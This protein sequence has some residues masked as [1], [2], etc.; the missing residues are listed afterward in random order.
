MLSE[1]KNHKP[2]VTADA[3]MRGE[4][5]VTPPKQSSR[6]RFQDTNEDD[7]MVSFRSFR[8]AEH[9][10]QERGQQ[11]QSTQRELKL[12]VQEGDDRQAQRLLEMRRKQQARQ[13][14][15]EMAPPPK[16]QQVVITNCPPRPIVPPVQPTPKPKRRRQ[17]PSPTWLDS[18]CASVIDATDCCQDREWCADNDDDNIAAEQNKSRPRSMF[19]STI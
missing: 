1:G 12:H 6:S 10:R 4:H 11:L 7:H 17:R 8:R 19:P 18:L 16:Q 15:R 2:K 14:E 13:L 3:I 5:K 9:V